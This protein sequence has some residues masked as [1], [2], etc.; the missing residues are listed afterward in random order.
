MSTI[1]ELAGEFLE[2]E[3]PIGVLIDP[4]VVEA[5]AVAAARFYFGYALIHNGDD[6]VLPSPFADI[7]LDT[8]LDPSEWAVIRPLFLL[9]VER[10]TALQL[11]ASRGLGADPYGRSSSEIASEITQYES[12]LP[13]KAF[14]QPFI[15]V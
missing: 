11:E 3:R 1:R 2:K 4:S 10:E 7:T 6:P 12:M 13:Q 9:Y 14:A 15:T 5:Q 8:D